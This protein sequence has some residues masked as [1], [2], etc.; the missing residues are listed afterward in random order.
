[1]NAIGYDDNSEIGGAY[2]DYEEVDN[3]KARRTQRPK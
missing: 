3:A 2:D 1:M